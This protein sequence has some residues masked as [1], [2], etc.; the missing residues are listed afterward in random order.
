MI[1]EAQENGV[2]LMV[3]FTERYSHPCAEAKRR[4][5]AGEDGKL[6]IRIALAAREAANTGNAVP[7]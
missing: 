7:I 4:I 6:A 5:D 2:I 1:R 3:G